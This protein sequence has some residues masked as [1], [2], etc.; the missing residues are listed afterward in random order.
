MLIKDMQW[1]WRTAGFLR[2]YLGAGYTEKSVRL[3]VHSYCLNIDY[4]KC[5]QLFSILHLL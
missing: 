4:C 1:E 2:L 5:L 3:G